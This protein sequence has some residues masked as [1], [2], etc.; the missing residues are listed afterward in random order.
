V[1]VHVGRSDLVPEL[2][3]YFQRQSDC[4]VLQVGETEIE[5]S[6]LGSYRVDRHDDAVQRLLAAFWLENGG[7]FEPLDGN[8][9][10]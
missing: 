4:V 6:L 7:P 2:I 5:V 3:Q 9:H 1:R 10:N 8:G